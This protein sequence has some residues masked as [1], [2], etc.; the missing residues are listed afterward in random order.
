MKHALVLSA[1]ALAAGLLAACSS[2]QP[3]AAPLAASSSQPEPEPVYYATT[4][5]EAPPGWSPVPV[6]VVKVDNTLAGRPQEGLGDADLI[7]EEPV[8][9]GLTRLLT[10]FESTMAQRVGPVRSIRSSDVGLVMPVNATVVASGG[11][12]EALAAYQKAQIPLVTEGM[13]GL[14]RD[15]GRAAPYNIFANLTRLTR[16]ELGTDPEQPYFDFGTTKLPPG[17]DAT[18]VDLTFSPSRSENWRWNNR[19]Y[20]EQPDVAFRPRTLFALDVR[21]FD[22][23]K[24]DAAGSPIPEIVTS[25]AGAGYMF[26]DGEAHRILWEKRSPLAPFRFTTSA[27]LVISVPP[28]RTWISLL[29]RKTGQVRLS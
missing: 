23:G 25:G 29:D 3:P 24:R 16:A 19:G 12:P 21:S 28:G 2:P 13:A 14:Q 5:R 17:G 20:W 26:R 6:V 22:T 18:R 4:G 27:G 7:I 8:E 15:A 9:G 11:S 1:A 10:F